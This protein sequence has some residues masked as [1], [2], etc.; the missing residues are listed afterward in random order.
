MS[1]SRFYWLEKLQVRIAAAAGIAA[2]YFLLWPSLRPSD[3]GAPVAFIAGGGISQMIIFAA[4]LW[5]VAG[6]AAVITVSGRPSGA[7]LGVVIAA[8]GLSLRTEPIRQL[9][10]VGK[11]DMSGLYLSLVLEVIV[12]GIVLF[13]AAAVVGIVRRLIGSVRPGW[14]WRGPLGGAGGHGVVGPGDERAAARTHPLELLG[15]LEA[16]ASSVVLKRRGKSAPS[17]VAGAKERDSAKAVLART[18]GCLLVGVFAV[19]VALVILTTSTDRGQ[20][21]FELFASFL[22]G[23]LVAHQLFPT[24]YMVVCWAMP[25]LV[26]VGFYAL[27]ALSVANGTAQAWITVPLYARAL[28]IDWVSA[29]GAGALLG[30]WTSWRMHERRYL[31]AMEPGTIS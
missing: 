25:I 24:P 13:F 17:T 7:L 5:V 19:T 22:V 9:L 1:P 14:I 12:L 27:A 30:Y 29:G 2:V 23:A 20:I 26:G 8:G 28:P 11:G 16:A 31:E 10:W 15:L 21:L 6:A 4:G 18:A 3:P